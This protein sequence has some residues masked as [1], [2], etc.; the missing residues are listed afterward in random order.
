MPR[1]AVSASSWHGPPSAASAPATSTTS[2]SVPFASSSQRVSQRS[3]SLS[4][5][6]DSETVEFEGVREREHVVRDRVERIR[7]D[8]MGRTTSTHPGRVD[9]HTGEIARQTRLRRPPTTTSSRRLRRRRGSPLVT[10]DEHDEADGQNERAEED[11]ERRLDR[12][13]SV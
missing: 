10:Q 1:R 7:L 5:G 6:P 12:D 11:T 3:A 9:K 13:H 2:A 4:T 8:P